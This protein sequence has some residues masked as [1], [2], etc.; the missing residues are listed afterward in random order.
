MTL[1]GRTVVLSAAQDVTEL[2]LAEDALRD[3]E[4]RYRGVVEE[5][6]E[7]ICV[8][9]VKGHIATWNRALEAMTGVSALTALGRPI[10][11][12]AS[13]IAPAETGSHERRLQLKPALLAFLETGAAPWG[14]ETLRTE[15]VRP[16][17]ATLAVR[18]RVF[19]VKTRQG[20]VLAAM[21][22]PEL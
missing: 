3:S 1:G 18:G 13:E 15:V 19:A 2:A 14:D 22:Q 16:D 5:A 12:V 6:G 7:G 8:T 11:D 20:F 21:V 17:G 4:V 9:D 10:W